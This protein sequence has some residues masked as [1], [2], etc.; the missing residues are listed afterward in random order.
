MGDDV[1]AHVYQD[2]IHND[3]PG[4][5]SLYPRVVYGFIP[6]ECI[7]HDLLAHAYT[8]YNFEGGLEW[9]IECC[10]R[11]LFKVTVDAPGFHEE[12]VVSLEPGLHY[13]LVELMGIQ[14]I[15]LSALKQIY[16]TYHEVACRNFPKRPYA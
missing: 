14:P 3:I 16:R 4:D 5:N 1:F 11:T 12:R 15:Q 10:D 9:D 7:T 6:A 8:E 2:L 13:G